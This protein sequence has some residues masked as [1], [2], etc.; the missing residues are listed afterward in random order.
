MGNVLRTLAVVEAHTAER[1][2]LALDSSQLREEVMGPRGEIGALTNEEVSRRRPN[3]ALGAVFCGTGRAGRQGGRRAALRCAAPRVTLG[4]LGRWR[5]A[6]ITP[7][8]SPARG[9]E[10][11]S[12]THIPGSAGPPN[13]QFGALE[14]STGRMHPPAQPAM[15][16]RRMV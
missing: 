3:C 16:A 15:L 4:G 6:G 12:R 10:H 7:P 11:P 5:W 14:H 9:D 2:R 1:R 13:T 8:K